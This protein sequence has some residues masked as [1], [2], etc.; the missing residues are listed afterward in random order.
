MLVG[1]GPE[2][3]AAMRE[4]GDLPA[5]LR[6]RIRPDR[7]PVQTA[8]L[9]QQC[10]APARHTVGAWPSTTPLQVGHRR[11]P[12]E[13]AFCDCPRCRAFGAPCAADPCRCPLCGTPRAG[14]PPTAAQESQKR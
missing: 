12:G 7:T 6:L 10:A 9:W 11:A 13:A 5:F 2:D 4:E 8:A 14:R 3:I 1:F